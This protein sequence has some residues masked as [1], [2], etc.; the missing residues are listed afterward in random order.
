MTMR[1]D[2][3]KKLRCCVDEMSFGAGA[4]S[5][6][7][8][9]H[10]LVKGYTILVLVCLWHTN[11]AMFCFDF[12][13][14]TNIVSPRDS[15]TR[16]GQGSRWAWWLASS[17]PVLRREPVTG[18]WLDSTEVAEPNP[19][20]ARTPAHQSYFWWLPCATN[21]IEGFPHA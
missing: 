16:C 1:Q 9:I 18:Q 19:T 10:C 12:G 4:H 17:G 21:C 14:V 7:R 11:T 15:D 8:C 20:N 13:D 6:V 2:I 3:S 5:F